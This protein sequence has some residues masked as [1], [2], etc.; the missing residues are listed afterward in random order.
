MDWKAVHVAALLIAS[1]TFL[2]VTEASPVR[3]PYLDEELDSCTEIKEAGVTIE[4][5]CAYASWQGCDYFET[6][7]Y[8]CDAVGDHNW[9]YSATGGVGE[10]FTSQYADEPADACLDNS[11]TGSCGTIQTGF[12]PC[13]V[14]WAETQG[15][16]TSDTSNKVEHPDCDSTELI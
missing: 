16:L 15:T 12:N 2:T 3:D 6:Y 7:G 8:I 1:T 14:A 10:L 13:R 5:T 11:V 4:K 9:M